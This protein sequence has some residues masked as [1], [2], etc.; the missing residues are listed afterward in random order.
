[1]LTIGSLFAGVGGMDKGL[2]DAGLGP[3]LWQVE[4]SPYCRAV[5]AR[6][7]PIAVRYPDVRTVRD[8][9]AVDVICGGFPCQDVSGAGKRVGLEG[10]RSGLWY[11]FAR[12][13]AESNPRFVIVENVASGKGRWLPQV[14]AQLCEL[15]YG[16]RAYALSAADVGAPHLRRR[17]FVVGEHRWSL[18]NGDVAHRD[19]ERLR[20]GAERLPGGWAG[21]VH[22]AGNTEPEHTGGAMGNG[23]GLQVHQQAGAAARAVGG[24]TMAHGHGHGREREPASWLHGQG[25]PGHDASRRHRFPPRRGDEDAWATWRACDGPEPGIRRGSN[26][27]SG[28]VDEAS[29]AAD[30]AADAERLEA[31]GNA[32]VPQCAEVIGRL[33]LEMAR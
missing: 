33:V 8:L 14:R 16:T 3:V 26:G 21:E 23:N 11:E 24:P 22:G 15:G 28:R 27:L 32:V 2:E 19:G 13:V 30:L 18:G 6:H 5:L 10:A 29:I 1:M 4:I 25:E 17:V 12:I 20:D 31:L 9:P 7:W